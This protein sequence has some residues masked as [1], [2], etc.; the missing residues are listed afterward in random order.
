MEKVINNNL[1]EINGG[2]N[3]GYSQYEINN[4][5]GDVLDLYGVKRTLNTNKKVIIKCNYECRYI[6]RSL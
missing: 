4:H 3:S 6:K 5:M 2:F 1:E